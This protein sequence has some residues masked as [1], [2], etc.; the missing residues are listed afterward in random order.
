MTDDQKKHIALEQEIAEQGWAWRWALVAAIQSVAAELKATREA[1]PLPS[2]ERRIISEKR[3][4]AGRAGGLKSAAGRKGEGGRFV[5]SKQNQ[6]NSKQKP[7]KTDQANTEQTPS[8]PQAKAKQTPGKSVRVWE[9]YQAAYFARYSVKP[10]RNHMVNGNLCTLVDRLGEHDAIRVAAFYLT[11]GDRYYL[12]QKHPTTLLVKD[13]QKLHTEMQTGTKTTTSQAVREEAG[14]NL[15]ESF[16]R[17]EERQKAR[18][19][20]KAQAAEGRHIED[21]EMPF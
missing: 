10:V 7:S 17:L 4:A 6:A 15:D 13:W 3:R 2:E 18:A 5:P 16:R 12:A 14:A 1:Q 8:K 11:H 9:S 21:E 20:A 19:A